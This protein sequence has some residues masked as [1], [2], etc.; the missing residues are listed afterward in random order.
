MGAD[1]TQAYDDY[2]DEIE[3]GIQVGKLRKEKEELFESL[4][5]YYRIFVLKGMDPGTSE[6]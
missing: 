6:A 4:E 2:Y 1:S 5:E 3:A